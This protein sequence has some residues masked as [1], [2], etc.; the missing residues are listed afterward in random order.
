MDIDKA[1]HGKTAEEQ[2]QGGGDDEAREQGGGGQGVTE[3]V[4]GV[5]SVTF[6][7]TLVCKGGATVRLF[8]NNHK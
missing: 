6:D 2:C 1:G 5:S 7:L 8:Y 4:R 3:E